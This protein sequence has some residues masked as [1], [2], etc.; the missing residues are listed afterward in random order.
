MS[1]SG[2]NNCSV[3]PSSS[4]HPDNYISQNIINTVQYKKD[5]YIYIIHCLKI[6]SLPHWHMELVF[7]CTCTHMH[8]QVK[9]TCKL[10]TKIDYE[11]VF[12][13]EIHNDVSQTKLCF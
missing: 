5:R 2:E 6:L 1:L 13:A 10:S 7:I 11:T 3:I 8:N 9:K 12:D 4:F